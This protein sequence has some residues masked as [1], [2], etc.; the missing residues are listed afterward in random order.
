M[1]KHYA[2]RRSEIDPRPSKLTDR[3]D[4]TIARTTESFPPVR[5]HSQ[6]VSSSKSTR[7]IRREVGFGRVCEY[8]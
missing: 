3:R 7:F 8:L 4:L 1:P 6:F 5:C 2:V